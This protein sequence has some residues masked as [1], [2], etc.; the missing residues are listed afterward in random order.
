MPRPRRGWIDHTCYHITHRCHERTFLLKFAKHRD[1]YV[2]QLRE[3]NKRFK[4]DMLDYIV[5]SNHVHILL[6]ARKAERI[7]EAIQ[8]LQGTFGQAY[9][10]EKQREGAFWRGRFHATAIQ[11]G[12]H[13][14]RALFYI[15][16][17]MV[18]VGVVRHPSEWKHS[19][20]HELS[21]TR[22]RYRIINT[23]RLRK[24]L[25]MSDSE[26]F[27]EWYKRTVDE[28]L[29]EIY[30]VR[31]AFWTEALAVGDKTWIEGISNK[32]T[33]RKKTTI[34]PVNEKQEIKEDIP[35]YYLKE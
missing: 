17:N 16:F 23:E 5:T 34:L 32:I 19:G 9:N 8:F 22:K 6:W 3:T 14:A 20:Y 10:R 7:S 28:K 24:C 1:R 13:L 35:M 29:S 4:I 33:S 26:Q 25:R 15:D 12:M 2:D 21:G 30:H 31:E 11:D 27:S 18:R